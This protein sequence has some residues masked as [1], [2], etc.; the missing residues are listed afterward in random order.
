MADKLKYSKTCIKLSPQ[1]V[2]KSVFMTD[3]DLMQVISIK[4]SFVIKTFVLS[5][6]EWPFLHRFYCTWKAATIFHG[7]LNARLHPL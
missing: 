2:R 7:F 6:F 4:L 3:Y 5:I 1:K